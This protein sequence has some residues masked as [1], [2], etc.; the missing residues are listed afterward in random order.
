MYSTSFTFILVVLSLVVPLQGFASI[1][2]NTFLIPKFIN[3]HESITERVSDKSLS[4]SK[5]STESASSTTTTKTTETETSSVERFS[6]YSIKDSFN[7]IVLGDLH[8]EDDMTSHFQARDD[9]LYVLEKLSLM[10]CTPSPSQTQQESDEFDHHQEHVDMTYDE[11][12]IELKKEEA[13]KLSYSQLEMLMEHQR[14]GTFANSVL[15]SLGDLG[16]KDIRHEPGDAGTTKS[17]ADARQFLDG[18]ELPYELVT[19]N[20]DLEGLD[21]FKTDRDNLDAW[22]KC[23]GKDTPYFSQQIGE[24]TV[25][26]GLSTVRFRDSPHSSH[27]CHVDDE[28]LS[29]FLQEVESH[30]DEEGWRLIVFSHAPIMGSNLRVLQ[31]VHV[32]NGCA[33]M[34][35][36]SPSTRGLFIETVKRNP[37]IKMW[38][39]G[40]FHLSHDFQD[41]ISRVNQC[42]FLQAGVI[43]PN[44][45]RDH[46]RQTRIVRGNNNSI[47][48]YTVNHHK[49]DKDGDAEFRLDAF[50]DLT[51]GDILFAHNC[52][53]YNHDK[54]FSAYVPEEEDGCYLPIPDGRV[55]SNKKSDVVCWWHMNDDKVLG[56]HDGQIVEYDETTLSP[57]GI[58]IS[59][60]EMGDREVLVV[61]NSRILVLVDP[62]TENMEVIHPNEDGSYWRK[63]QRNKRIRL[64]EKAR[65]EAAKLWI[66][67]KKQREAFDSEEMVVNKYDV[68]SKKGSKDTNQDAFI[69]KNDTMTDTLILGVLDGHGE[70]GDM[71]AQ[72][73]RK[74]L[75]VAMIEH[76]NWTTDIKKA[77]SEAISKVEQLVNKD[78]DTKLSGTTLSMAIIRGNMITAVNIGD[79]RVIV[80]KSLDG[81]IE[82]E[83][84]TNDHKPDTPYEYD[85]ILCSGGTVQNDFG[86]A[87]VGG[88]AMSRSL[89][90]TFVHTIGVSSEPEFRERPLDPSTDKFILVATDGLWEFISCEETAQLINTRNSP[91]S[92]VKSL[93]KEARERWETEGPYFDDTT[94][95][96]AF[97]Y[98][99]KTM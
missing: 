28:Q 35:H 37:Q 15:V 4:A 24:K 44:S 54:W 5:K 86:T 75:P 29:W 16:R 79:S 58:V 22:M 30:P 27:E 1:P 99:S 57:L 17:F 7:L 34:N 9:C 78:I 23:Y 82:V 31:N 95:I 80:G 73:F 36:C 6:E 46:T 2:R 61:D 13:G 53:D 92:S 49:R 66:E 12:I 52:E 33:W 94:I 50:M 19:G 59:K 21:E 96:L 77:T 76:P 64:E 56:V 65:E 90:D 69:M 81:N 11:M 85:R 14:Q 45:T 25:L 83:T 91:K 93:V 67:R 68:I 41:S 55:A 88:L 63:F 3:N 18:F 60:K 70:Y 38:C 51:M 26:I 39:S 74:Q 71:V 40:H 48:I 8:L 10:P 84:F 97:L 43:G 42:T 32:T 47:E 87:R 20:H 98:D 62:D 89:G 72:A